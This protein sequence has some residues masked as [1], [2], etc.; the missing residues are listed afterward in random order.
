MTYA[1]LVVVVL[2]GVLIWAKQRGV[3]HDW[4]ETLR[5]QLAKVYPA[6]P[7]SARA[8]PR[9]LLRAAERTLSVGVSGAILVP[10]HIEIRVHPDDLA[11][12]GDAVD[13]L[14]RDIASALRKQALE[15]QWTLPAG[16]EIEIVED[17]ERPLRL[18]RALGRFTALSAQDVE[19][20]RTG[21]QPVVPGRAAETQV[22]PDPTRAT[23]FSQPDGGQV[24]A[25]VMH[26]RLVAVGQAPATGEGDLNL[27]LVSG[28][29]PLLLGRSRQAELQIQDTQVSGQ[30][31]RF[32]VDSGS[33]EPVVE[34]VGSTNGTY[35]AGSKVTRQ[36]LRHGDTLQLGNLAWRVELDAL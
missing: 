2:A 3:L 4:T 13:W 1:L 33:G 16:P 31:C 22:A 36:T 11:A 25:R 17:P 30:H 35:V 15:H 6:R 9:K 34:D 5:E 20:I 12:F 32:F 7:L 10:S 8:L 24:T 27:M 18:P 14:S 28:Q 23:A 26:L 29:A 21:S 19:K